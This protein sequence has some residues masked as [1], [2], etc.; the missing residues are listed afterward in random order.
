M[1]SCECKNICKVLGD[2]LIF[3][4]KYWTRFG[5]VEV[6]Y[7]EKHEASVF[8]FDEKCVF[9]MFED[10]ILEN[11]M[12]EANFEENDIN[13]FL[14]RIKFVSNRNKMRNLSLANKISNKLEKRVIKK[15][16]GVKNGKNKNK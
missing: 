11:V 6:K 1:K 13:I 4:H 14:P 5:K 15:N 2:D 9:C 3:C 12:R 10:G 16:K 7:C 8:H